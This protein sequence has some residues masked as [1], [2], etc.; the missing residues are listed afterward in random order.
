MLKNRIEQRWKPINGVQAYYVDRSM[1]L[2]HLN[3]TGTSVLT[4]ILKYLLI[5][6]PQTKTNFLFFCF[7]RSSTS[8]ARKVYNCMIAKCREGQRPVTLKNLV[9]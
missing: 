7:S 6:I 8:N 5:R 3:P 9:E 2:K 4:I 1:F